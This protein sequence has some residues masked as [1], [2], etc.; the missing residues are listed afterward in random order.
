MTLSKRKTRREILR[1]S[2]GVGVLAASLK[3]S[4]AAWLSPTPAQPAGPFYAPFKPLSIDNDLVFLPGRTQRADGETLHIS[5]RVRGQTGKSIAGARVEIWQANRYG[6]Y[7]HPRHENSNLKL[8]PNFQG[9]GHDLT[10]DAG[11]YRFRTIKPGAYP[12]SPNWLRPPHIHFAVFPPGGPP[13]TT[14]LYFAGEP[15]NKTDFLLQGLPTDIARERVTMALKPPT[16]ELEP[17]SRT[18]TF[19]I[20]L[21]TPGVRQ[22]KI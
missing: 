4:A 2:L 19:N 20:V 6:R 21:G 14:Q 11:G 22:E 8:D 16:P 10:D 18:G 17:D 13:W 9:F 15:L 1:A 3:P 5:G 7:N 12:D